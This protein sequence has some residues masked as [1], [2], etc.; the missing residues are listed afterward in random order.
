MSEHD[1]FDLAVIGG[2]PA[3]LAAA[4]AASEASLRVAVLDESP[5]L[6]GRLLGQLHQK[7]GSSG[8]WWNGIEVAKGLVERA[9]AKG[10]T[11]LPRTT[12]WDLQPGFHAF[13]THDA[14][15]RRIDAQRVLIATGAAEEPVPVPGWQLP[16]VLSI[17]GAQV[18]TNVH[19]VRPGRRAVVIGI[20]VLS[21]A[22][23]RELALAGVQV[24]ALV[25]PAPSVVAGERAVPTR[26]MRD[27]I[28]LAR[29]APS[30]LLRTA[31]PVA[32]RLGLHGL[33]TRLFPR[34][35]FPLWG[36][37]IRPTV[38][39]TRIV[40]TEQVE[41]VELAHLTPHG[42]VIERSTKRVPVDLVCI[43]GG[44][45]PLI[46]LATTIGCVTYHD[47]DLGGHV[48]LH[49]GRFRTTVPDAYVT[50]NTTGVEGAEVA[51]AQGRAAGYA[52]AHDAHGGDDL[53][54]RLTEALAAV[55][56]TR[57]AA[58]IRFIPTIERGRASVAE[59]WTRFHATRS[60]A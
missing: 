38:A 48:P 18:V 53:E 10:V 31:G 19:R 42:S 52:I 21:V 30:P 17:G 51:M 55:R 34:S 56:T 28:D 50:G 14:R 29:L 57:A 22:I 44:L 58:D 35:G 39:A 23:A 6:G 12:V 4:I 46:E 33:A 8:G 45:Y 3:G 40:G 1:R 54:R 24:V 25:L 11:L 41:A 16:G 60:A 9:Q 2:G 20:N 32:A 47:D 15:Q 49:D 13:T 36:I 27:L 37:P 7:P 5:Q 59:A 26:V 43:A